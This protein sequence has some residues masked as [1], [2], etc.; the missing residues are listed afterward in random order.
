MKFS[1]KATLVI[2]LVLSFV[3]AIFVF[4]NAE[5]TTVEQ[6]SSSEEPILIDITNNSDNF[7]FLE[8]FSEQQNELA[9]TN[10]DYLGI[11]LTVIFAFFGLLGTLIYFFNIRPS[12]E[13]IKQQKEELKTTKEE[14][15]KTFSELTNKQEKEMD[16]YRTELNRYK[17][18][19]EKDRKEFKIFSEKTI[20]DIKEQELKIN[21]RLR[22]HELNLG[23]HRAMSLALHSE[24]FKDNAKAILYWVDSAYYFYKLDPSH[25]NIL[26][27]IRRA[28]LSLEKIIK[29]DTELLG[30]LHGIKEQLNELEK[31]YPELIEEVKKILEEKLKIFNQ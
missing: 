11:I 8:Y 13:D 2:I 29:T 30:F 14:L 5:T 7:N 10:R 24:L 4:I 28:K 12:K 3:L 25:S 22:V 23:A 6:I 9:Q 21:S 20:S 27:S 16:A 31:Q 15:K 18:E 1:I 17:Q 19:Q 26:I